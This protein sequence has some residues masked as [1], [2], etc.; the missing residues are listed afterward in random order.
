MLSIDDRIEAVAVDHPGIG[1]LQQ[2]ILSNDGDEFYVGS[3]LDPRVAGVERMDA[4]PAGLSDLDGSAFFSAPWNQVGS[5]SMI[6]RCN[7]DPSEVQVPYT[8][9]ACWRLG[10]VSCDPFGGVTINFNSG[11]PGG[12]VLLEVRGARRQLRKQDECFYQL[13]YPKDVH[14]CSQGDPRVHVC[15]LNGQFHCS[16]K[17][18]RTF[19]QQR[20][21]SV[22]GHGLL[23]LL[24]TRIPCCC[25]TGSSISPESLSSAGPYLCRSL[26]CLSISVQQD[27]TTFNIACTPDA[28][29]W[30]HVGQLNFRCPSVLFS[31]QHGRRRFVVTQIPIGPL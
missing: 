19:T 17:D 2:E 16:V 27:T 1:L 18:C 30:L 14:S 3:M 28:G 21:D 22:N 12:N 4:L 9:E 5:L 31:L 8:A 13:N 6:L 23:K 26:L 20:I 10:S 15:G 25:D 7:R 11:I 29:C 24:S